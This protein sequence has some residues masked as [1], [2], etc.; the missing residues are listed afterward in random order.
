MRAVCSHVVG[1]MPASIIRAHASPLYYHMI[2]DSIIFELT[3]RAERREAPQTP[4]HGAWHTFKG[5][6][7]NVIGNERSR[8]RRRSANAEPQ[9]HIQA[10]SK[11][12]QRHCP[13]SRS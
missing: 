13:P 10:E 11:Q 5:S 6:L 2:L 3:E 4:V 7:L 12:L 1:E 9:R 8:L